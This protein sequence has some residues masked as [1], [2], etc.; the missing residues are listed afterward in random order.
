M[1]IK[2]KWLEVFI[3]GYLSKGKATQIAKALKHKN[4]IYWQDL[5]IMTRWRVIISDNIILHLV[6]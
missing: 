4:T 2:L 1:P 3:N 6:T 5:Y